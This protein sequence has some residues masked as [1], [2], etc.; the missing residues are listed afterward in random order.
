MKSGEGPLTNAC[1]RPPYR[2][3]ISAAT[4][5]FSECCYEGSFPQPG[6]G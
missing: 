6:G 3:Y 2:A 1:T 5:A 4:R